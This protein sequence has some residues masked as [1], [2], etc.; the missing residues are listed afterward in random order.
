[1]ANHRIQS[2]D[3]TALQKCAKAVPVAIRFASNCSPAPVDAIGLSASRPLPRARVGAAVAGY[4]P[5]IVLFICLNR[6]QGTRCTSLLHSERCPRVA[7]CA[8]VVLIKR[9]T[10]VGLLDSQVCSWCSCATTAWAPV[11]LGP[12][13]LSARP[14]RCVLALLVKLLGNVRNAGDG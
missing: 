10:L 5:D 6:L 11:A 12:Q 9:E 1:M 4:V 8:L 7:F 14:Y 2:I 3:S 13:S